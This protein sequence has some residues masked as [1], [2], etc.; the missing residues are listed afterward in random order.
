MIMYRVAH[1]RSY[2][3]DSKSEVCNGDDDGV[4]DQRWRGDLEINIEERWLEIQVTLSP[5]LPG[6]LCEDAAV[7]LTNPCET[8]KYSVPTEDNFN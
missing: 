2:D 7:T 1:L 8:D 5:N 3:S 4:E 6:G